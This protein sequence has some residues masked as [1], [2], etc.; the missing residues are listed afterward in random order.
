MKRCMGALC[1]ALIFLTSL[2]PAASALTVEQALGLLEANYVEELPPGAYEAE[3]L[4][5]LIRALGDPYTEYMTREG[6]AAFL[7]SVENTVE[8]VGIGVSIR[9]TPDGI[10]VE[11]VLKGG[12]A[13]DA[14][15]RPGDVII[16]V[17]GVSC[18]PADQSHRALIA[19]EEG[20]FVELTVRRDGETLSFTVERRKVVIPNTEVSVVDGHIGLV[21]CDS[22]GSA[23]GEL[24]ARGVE[25]N[26]DA[27][28]SWLVDLRGNVGGVTTSAVEAVGVFGGPGI[29]LYLQA[30]SGMLYYY[31][32]VLP[33]AT[34]HPVVV[35][36]DGWTASAAEAF[37]ADIRDLGL[38][39]TVGRRTYGKGVAQTVY[40]ENNY[41]LYFD[42]DAL[43]LTAYRFYSTGGIT[44][45]RIGVIPTLLVDESQTEAVA[46]ALCGASGAAEGDLLRI[47]LPETAEL[48]V[49]LRA[50]EP[51]ALAALLAALP[52]QAELE[53]WGGV[54]T[55]AEVANW[56]GMAYWDRWC[57]DLQDSPFADR[58]NALA[59]Y[60]IVSGDEEGRFR[61]DDRLTRGE[62]CAMLCQALNLPLKDGN[63]F[64]D[65]SEDDPYAPYINAVARMGLVKGDGQ[66]RFAPD[67]RVTQEQCCVILSRLARYLS[68]RVDGIAREM[69]GQWLELAERQGFASWACGDAALMSRLGF[70][71]FA[72]DA[73]EP[74]TRITRG[75]F[76]AG[77]Y[78]VLACTGILPVGRGY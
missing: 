75:E 9:F 16:A 40:D 50:M 64:S 13:L 21:D 70:E 14:G 72:T 67:E 76:A 36:T 51:N 61:P 53:V 26:R 8:L 20:T 15:L 28:D 77:L 57:S 74:Q 66:G 41:P 65:V 71:C 58:I 32:Y 2:I 63:R 43:K 54:F 5:S 69:T 4:E 34:D 3:D 49:D 24:F 52:P 68:L 18:V 35:M 60:G 17:E 37:A 44:N 78:E 46:K 30:R 29:P 23:T 1:A 22:F 62:M 19:G 55:P 10:Y 12:G 47:R 31:Q 59:T 38:G 42:G 33:A 45:D 39:I 48:A 6:Y 7:D 56:L 25:E 73:F 27:V 11:S